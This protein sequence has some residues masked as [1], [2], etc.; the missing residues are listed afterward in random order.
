ML[1]SSYKQAEDAPFLGRNGSTMGFVDAIDSSIANGYTKTWRSAGDDEDLLALTFDGS[2]Q[3]RLG[4][5]Y[6]NPLRSSARFYLAANA[7]LATQ[8][9]FV[10]PGPVIITGLDEIHATAG[11]ASGA[12]TLQVTH[13]TGTQAPGTGVSVTSNTFNLKGTANTTQ[14]GTLAAKYQK[15]TANNTPA[16]G[17]AGIIKLS[18]GDRLSA[19]FTGTLT[20]LAGVALDVFFSPGGITPLAVYQMNAAA[21]QVTTSIFTAMQPTTVAGFTCVVNVPETATGTCT[22]DLFKDTG[23]NAPGGGATT[24][25]A[26]IN[27]KTIVANTTTSAALSATASALAMNVGDRLSVVFA[28]SATLTA[29]AGVCAVAWLRPMQNRRI[30]TYTLQASAAQGTS[31]AFFQADRDYIVTDICGI[32]STVAGTSGRLGVTA[33][34]GTTAPGSGQSLTTDNSN[35]GFD[36]TGTINTVNWGTL[37]ATHLLYLRAGDRL[38]AKYGGTQSSF[39]GAELNV[40]LTAI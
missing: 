6:Q 7:G 29:L 21:A 3:L 10:A 37:A 40:L 12:V 16:Q 11:T 9:I 25:A 28:G 23:T 39:A 14:T 22:L 32:W 13:E 20:T 8:T 30:V 2:N 15:Q 5:A 31:Q 1:R 36:T 19:K 33:E 34:T 17:G 18:A 27:L 26:A 35:A 4:N 24:L 38:S